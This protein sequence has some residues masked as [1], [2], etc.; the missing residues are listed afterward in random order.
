K[1][2]ILS[3]FLPLLL[4]PSRCAARFRNPTSPRAFV[5]AHNEVRAFLG[6]P[7]LVWSPILAAYARNYANQSAGDCAMKHSGGPYG[8]NLASGSWDLTAK[9]AVGL[10]LEEKVGFLTNPKACM[11]SGECLHYTQ[12]VWR[13][14]KAVGCGRAKCADGWTFVVCSYDPPGNFVGELPY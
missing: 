9:E 13:S 3:I 2:S 10:W 8:E 1:L 7:P 4:A 6:E 14:T 5:G 11:D 12:V